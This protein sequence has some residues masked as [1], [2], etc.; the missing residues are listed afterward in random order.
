MSSAQIEK[1]DEA[2]NRITRFIGITK[3]SVIRGKAKT[4]LFGLFITVSVLLLTAVVSFMRPL[5]YNVEHK[6]NDHILNRECVVY[7]EELDQIPQETAHIRTMEHVKNVFFQP[8]Q[9]EASDT[10]GALF[11]FYQLD[12]FHPGYEPIITAG[13]GFDEKEKNVVLVPEQFSDYNEEKK[14]TTQV[15]GTKLIGK[16]LLMQDMSGHIHKLEVIGAYNTADPL[17]SGTQFIIPQKEL[18]RF[19]QQCELITPKIQERYVVIA[20]NYKNLGSLMESLR[21][22]GYPVN[23]EESLNFDVEPYQ[24]AILMLSAMFAVFVVM[25]LAGACI[26]I[27]SCLKNRKKEIALYRAL[28]YKTHHIFQVFALEYLTNGMICI[29]LGVGLWQLAAYLAV[30]PYLD[31]LFGNTIMAMS[32]TFNLADALIILVIFAAIILLACL[33]TAVK[34]NRIEPIV[35]LREG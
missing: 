17:F 30:N 35:L 6:I 10:S 26:F 32:L 31:T 34:S 13:R 4:V 3:A 27:S 14:Q 9:V 20:D 8:P 18:Y 25:I 19:A 29:V 2:M 5:W 24:T 28:G 21:A 16:E 22:N 33:R 23:K 7:L 15:D 1:G 12:A 11:G